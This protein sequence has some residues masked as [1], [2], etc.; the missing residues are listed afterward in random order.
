MFRLARYDNIDAFDRQVWKQ[1]GWSGEELTTHC[2]TAVHSPLMI[3]PWLKS[4]Q[5][6]AWIED[7]RSPKYRGLV[8]VRQLFV[9][10]LARAKEVV[11]IRIKERGQWADEG[12]NT[13]RK[14]HHAGT[15]G[16]ISLPGKE[17]QTLLYIL[18]MGGRGTPLGLS[19]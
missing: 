11:I 18:Q 6:V 12:L 14:F 2:C 1:E 8:L 13:G 10:C 5:P 3:C 7:R 17:A 15:S 19:H 4:I 16:F 9:L